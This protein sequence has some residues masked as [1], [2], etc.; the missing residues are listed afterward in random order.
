MP[1]SI[2]LALQSFWLDGIHLYSEKP[3]ISLSNWFCQENYQIY[4]PISRDKFDISVTANDKNSLIASFAYDINRMSSASFESILSIGKLENKILKKSIAWAMIKIYYASFFAAHTIIKFV[5]KSCS[6]IDRNG[7]KSIYRIA[8][9]FSN[10]NNNTISTGLYLCE[11]NSGQGSSLLQCQKGT[12]STSH[13]DFWAI[14]CKIMEEIKDEILSKP[15][16]INTIQSQAVFN[17]IDM[18]IHNLTKGGANDGSW[19]SQIR[20]DIN[21]SQKYGV[22]FPYNKTMIDNKKLLDSFKKWQKDPMDIEL[23]KTPFKSGDEIVRFQNTCLFLIALCRE[24]VIYLNSKGKNGK[25]FLKY[26]P[27]AILNSI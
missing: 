27:M 24:L 25:S 4:S 17:K 21:Y 5:G 23:H 10:A 1:S 15:L 9:L 22:W 19:L 14:F 16:M 12:S 3:E 13:E 8:D 11:F 26:G 2:T 20:N 18:L 6:H 7:S